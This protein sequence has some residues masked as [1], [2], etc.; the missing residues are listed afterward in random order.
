MLDKSQRDGGVLDESVQ[1]YT[2]IYRILC[3]FMGGKRS[4]WCGSFS[5]VSQSNK[6]FNEKAFTQT[7]KAVQ[8]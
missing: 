8:G 3:I 4:K 1:F 5:G 6:N 7:P 2:V